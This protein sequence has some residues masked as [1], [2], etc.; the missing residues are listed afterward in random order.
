MKWFRG[1]DTGIRICC[2][3]VAVL[4]DGKVVRPALLCLVDEYEGAGALIACF[5]YFGKFYV[6]E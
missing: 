3:V 5:V 1:L 6:G 4:A 2:E